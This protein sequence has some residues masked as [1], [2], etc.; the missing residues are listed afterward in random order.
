MSS[1]SSSSSSWSSLGSVSI[2]TVFLLYTG[3]NFLDELPWDNIFQR[4]PPPIF[5]SA[6]TIPTSAD[7][8]FSSDPTRARTPTSSRGPE[9]KRD[10]DHEQSSEAPPWT[11]W[12]FRAVV[13]A[14]RF[15]RRRFSG[16]SSG[17]RGFFAGVSS[18]ADALRRTHWP[19]SPTTA[20]AVV[21]AVIFG[22][23][24]IWSVI[25]TC[26]FA[27]SWLFW[28]ASSAIFGIVQLVYVIYQFIM[29]FTDVFLLS[30][31]KTYSVLRSRLLQ[32]GRKSQKRIWRMKLRSIKSY[33]E[34]V[35]LLEKEEKIYHT[36]QPARIYPKTKQQNSRSP[37]PIHHN[38]STKQE[39]GNIVSDV[40]STATVPIQRSSSAGFLQ[41]KLEANKENYNSGTAIPVKTKRK[42]RCK[43]PAHP[44]SSPPTPKTTYSAPPLEVN[45]NDTSPTRRRSTLSHKDVAPTPISR[46][47]RSSVDL[48]GDADRL[49]RP[50]AG[51]SGMTGGVLRTTTGRLATARRDGDITALLFLLSG[52]VKRNHLGIDDLLQDDARA[53]YETGRSSLHVD[54][55]KAIEEFMAETTACIDMLSEYDDEGAGERR[56]SQQQQHSSEGAM[57]TL[58]GGLTT[59]VRS[60]RGGHTTPIQKGMLKASNMNPYLK[61]LFTS[62]PDLISNEDDMTNTYTESLDSDE[63]MSERNEELQTM[64]ERINVVHK[65]KQNLGRTGLMLS[66]GG[67]ITMYHLGKVRGLIEAGIYQQIPVISGTSGGSITAAMC[68]LKRPDEMLED[69]CIPGIAT[70]FTKDGY[71]RRHNIRWFP[72]PTTMVA[73]WMRTG[74]L[75]DSKEFKRT[76]TYYFGTTTFEE[77]YQHTGKT[78]CITV[79]ASRARADAG[80]TQRLLLNHVSTPHVTIAS[81]VAASCALP[82]V[83]A[84]ATLE[85]KGQDGIL[86]N[87]EVDGV[88][89]IDGS[90]QADIPFQR[91]GTL[92]NVTNFVVC[93]ANFHV[94]PILN[95]SHHPGKRSLY[96]KMFQTLVW[97]IR[98]RVLNLSRL[99]LF[100]R[101][102]GQDVSK[103]FKQKYHGD[104][105]IIARMSTMQIFGVKVLSNPTI[106]DMKIY[107]AHGQQATWPNVP[108]INHMLLL[109]QA[110]EKCASKIEERINNLSHQGWVGSRHSDG[111]MSDTSMSLSLKIRKGA[112]GGL[113]SSHRNVELIK[114]R[115]A[116]LESENVVLRRQV[117]YVI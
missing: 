37:S 76:C 110:L 101:F 21:L 88:E 40:A 1:L 62:P 15:A 55:R 109:E 66:G 73:N 97:D 89:W 103:V 35:Q 115:N 38:V 63:D 26:L 64:L 60:D 92:F 13:S 24:T 19:P 114:A 32:A 23:S 81:A 105:T 75:C 71:Q 53:L 28:I 6:F 5:A 94:Q 69:V 68:A 7:V 39:N 20:A 87:F 41:R 17:Y 3:V 106:E 42:K 85:A 2:A 44:K 36:Q 84:P 14:D 18:R 70:D 54:A 99:G 91:I 12:L 25:L 59:P 74:L 100:P 31:L 56:F 9:D 111:N 117:G 93:Q 27:S 30:V 16:L 78:V 22:Y 82:G 61:S 95:K 34:F 77:A 48:V 83:M 72:T 80:G 112:Y 8:Y 45:L 33:Q 51:L 10:H 116:F 49:A 104:V 57:N 52:I 47:A 50:V 79:S 113:Q 29:V 4:M 96:W 90:V 65:M 98:N 86:F 58:V 43:S 102:F 46:N 107:L 11:R 108:V 67:A